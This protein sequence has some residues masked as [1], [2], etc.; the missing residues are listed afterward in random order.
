MTS[1]D[2]APRGAR[3]AA[4]AVHLSVLD[5]APDFVT[6]MTDVLGERATAIRRNGGRWDIVFSL[7]RADGA[8]IQ[9]SAP[10]TPGQP[11]NEAG[12]TWKL[13]QLAADV[14]EVSPSVNLIG[15]YHGFL[16]IRGVP[17]PAPWQDGGGGRARSCSGRGIAA[18]VSTEPS[19][20][21][22]GTACA[23]LDCP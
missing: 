17:C 5:W 3:D 1:D 11:S 13:R 18:C 10:F 16:V 15:A 6:T 22:L 23:A 21:P 7:L 14:W 19:T 8:R 2:T 20:D 4:R 9:S 12:P